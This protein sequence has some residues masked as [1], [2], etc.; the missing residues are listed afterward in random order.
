MKSNTAIKATGLLLGGLGQPGSP[1]ALLPPFGKE[2][3]WHTMKK[4][5]E[6]L[7]NLINP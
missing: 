1:R 2:N 4:L 3:K 5:G 7:Q 6:P